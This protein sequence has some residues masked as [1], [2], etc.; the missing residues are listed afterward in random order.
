MIHLDK[1][2][3][4]TSVNAKTVQMFVAGKDKLFNTA[5]D[6]K[7]PITISLDNKH[8]TLTLLSNL[9]A[10]TS[11]RVHLL[12]SAITDLDG[13]HLDGE[14]SGTFPTGNGVQ[15]GDFNFR[16]DY[17]RK[18]NV[19]LMSTNLGLITVRMYP[20]ITP[21][22]AAN[23]MAYANSGRYDGT[24]ASGDGRTANPSTNIVQA[25]GYT[26]TTLVNGAPVHISTFPPITPE[27][28][29]ANNRGMVAM[30]PAAGGVTCDLLFNT[31][32]NAGNGAFGTVIGGMSI[33]D[34]IFAASTIASNKFFSNVP[35]IGGK[36]IVFTRIAMQAVVTA[37]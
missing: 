21:A 17:S 34:Q 18:Y 7:V 20:S 24:I 30:A 36:N 2:L 19:A 12:A 15:G 10:N 23:F 1:S 27:S 33:V 5:D 28:V 26:S 29:L 11:Y 3:F 8:N 31:Q 25:G 13:R 32:N 35:I 6:V 14:F 22:T 16:A 9:P 37:F 4:P